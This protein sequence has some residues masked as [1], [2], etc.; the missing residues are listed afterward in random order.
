MGLVEGL[1]VET[2]EFKKSEK[3]I[4][5]FKMTSDNKNK[6][7]PKPFGPPNRNTELN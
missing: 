6:L 1:E 5:Y 2:N 3:N 4:S 7:I